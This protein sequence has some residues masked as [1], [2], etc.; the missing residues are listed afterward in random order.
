MIMAAVSRARNVFFT[1]VSFGLGESTFFIEIKN[2]FQFLIII[3][4]CYNAGVA[5]VCVLRVNYIGGL[6]GKGQRAAENE[7]RSPI[8]IGI[9]RK[10]PEIS[11]TPDS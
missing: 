7:T 2:H 11:P 8:I 3:N 5:W 1:L 9:K 4:Y 6:E 10:E